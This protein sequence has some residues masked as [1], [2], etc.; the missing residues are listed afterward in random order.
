M[1][2][3]QNTG[4][5]WPFLDRPKCVQG[6]MR[7]HR[8]DPTIPL[9]LHLSFHGWKPTCPRGRSSTELQR[10][11]H[12]RKGAQGKRN[13]RTRISWR[14]IS[15]SDSCGGNASLSTCFQNT[16]AQRSFWI[17]NI[18]SSNKFFSQC[19]WVF[20]QFFHLKLKIFI[21]VC[22]VCVYHGT[23]NS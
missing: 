20:N 21:L 9:I 6:R 1:K 4:P 5:T 12:G 8:Q 18:S 19:S 23:I 3:C 10:P 22:N 7:A 2:L 14:R 11:L 15:V 17:T 16:N 13:L